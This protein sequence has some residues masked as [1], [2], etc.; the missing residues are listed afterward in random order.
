MNGPGRIS[1]NT[2][3]RVDL[4]EAVYKKVGLSRPEAAKLVGPVLAKMEQIVLGKFG[5]PHIGA[6][7]GHR[8]DRPR[9]PGRNPRSSVASG[10]A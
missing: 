4:C 1:N 3:T 6:P 5:D 2:V 7:Q 10:T 9:R 8:R